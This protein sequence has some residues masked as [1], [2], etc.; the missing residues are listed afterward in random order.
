MKAFTFILQDLKAMTGHKHR[1]IAL[2]FL[3]LVPLIYSGLFLSGYWNPY[4]KLEQLPVAVVNEDQGAVM[5]GEPIQAG[6]AFVQELKT[7]GD[8]DFKFVSS[9]KAEEGLEKGTYYMI[10]TI[11]EDFS[12]KVSTLM[13]E[14]PQPARLLYKDNPGKNF[15]AS[16]I[17]ASATEKMKNKLSDTI[18]KSYADG[19]FDKFVELGKG[20]KTASDGASRLHEGL[21]EE[22]EGM[23]T[24]EDGISSL[25]AGSKNLLSGSD[26]L[27]T[28]AGTIEAGL[29]TLKSSTSQLASG[30]NSLSEAGREIGVGAA[31]LSGQ[32]DQLAVAENGVQELQ[33]KMKSKAEELQGQL[34]EYVE[35]HPEAKDDPA[36]A[37][38]QALSDNISASTAE[39]GSRQS[40]IHKRTKGI[41]AGQMEQSQGIT[42]LADKLD[43]ASEGAADLASGTSALSKGFAD[44]QNGFSTLAT[45]IVRLS[46]GSDELSAGAS[47]L[48][49]GLNS[50]ESGSDELAVKLSDASDKTSG[51]HPSDQLS[52]MFSNP[53]QLVK[54]NLSEVPNYGTGIA[55]YFLSLALYVGGI[56]AANIL[57]LGRR[58]DL[59]VSGTTHFVN[60]FGLVFV[61]G[62][63]QALIVNLVLLYGFHLEV[64]NIPLFFLSSVIVSFTFM[65]FIFMLITVFGFVGKFLAVTFLVLQLATCG[66]T[67]PRDLNSPILRVIG[68]N[69]PMAHSL[70]S[71]QEVITLGDFTQLS[72][73]L[74]ILFAYLSVAG[75]IALFTSNVQVNKLERAN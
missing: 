44:W 26:K 34:K 57:P 33:S 50:L 51:I 22:K 53:V 24:L 35:A 75:G 45:G 48:S 61:I 73:Q 28:G 19:V 62:F 15:V 70:S 3:L 46:N 49:N 7:S 65:A 27:S 14:D 1:I 38:I 40:N 20:L 74:W 31:R 60:K 29:Q 39:I 41:A 63:I 5:E 54:S 67:F 8:L 13:E 43:G 66:G 30:V 59:K 17:S 37:R 58:D 11:P 25:E 6:N 68:E 64:V 2:A 23:T 52:T 9:S 4:G 32:A 10:V 36:F 12:A 42:G 16:Q 47:E 55:P 18:T 56:M 21:A 69:L 71:F 72:H